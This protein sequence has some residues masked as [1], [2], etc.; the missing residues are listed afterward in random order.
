M[1]RTEGLAKIGDNPVERLTEFAAGLG[2]SPD[3]HR[4]LG[5]TPR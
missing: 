3:E 2:F 5:L 4:E 1:S